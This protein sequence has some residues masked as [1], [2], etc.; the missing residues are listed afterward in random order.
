MNTL[1]DAAQSAI[2]LICQSKLC[3]INSMSSRAE[4]IRLLDK[5]VEALRK[6]LADADGMGWQPIETAPKNQSVLLYCS[7]AYVP[8]YCGMKRYGDPSEPQFN[9][10]AWR[11]DSSGT[12]ASPTHWMPIPKPP[13]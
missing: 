9:E 2:D 6:A 12:F 1:R 11:C 7:A 10:L 13:R 5:A 4:S 8:I 3:E